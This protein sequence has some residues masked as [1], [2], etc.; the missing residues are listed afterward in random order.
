MTRPSKRL[1]LREEYKD[2]TAEVG[3]WLRVTWLRLMREKVVSFD[4]DVRTNRESALLADE[5]PRLARVIAQHKTAP[6]EVFENLEI[7]IRLRTIKSKHFEE[8]L[9]EQPDDATLARRNKDHAYFTD[10]LRSTLK[11]LEEGRRLRQ[12]ETQQPETEAGGSEDKVADTDSHLEGDGLLRD[13]LCNLP[14]GDGQPQDGHTPG[15]AVAEG[16]DVID[17]AASVAEERVPCT[18]GELRRPLL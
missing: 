13:G 10:V 15:P 4:D 18:E 9:L 7:A 8:Q 11:V 1:T 14:L 3:L 2:A 17:T 6:P 12:P 16:C 5:Y